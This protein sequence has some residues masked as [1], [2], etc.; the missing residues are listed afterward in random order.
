M[1]KTA[2]SDDRPH[3]ITIIDRRMRGQQPFGGRYH[4]ACLCGWMG[5]WTDHYHEAYNDHDEHLRHIATLPYVISANSYR[6]PVA[7][8]PGRVEHRVSVTA[9]PYGTDL[10]CVC[11]W[12]ML[13]SLRG[14][15]EVAGSPG[16]HALAIA[17]RHDGL[18]HSTD[19]PSRGGRS[20]RH[21]PPD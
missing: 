10:D 18:D 8:G 13:V 9:H 3:A 11:G 6:E 20:P 5:K 1:H 12:R 7:P 14:G 16:H 17:Q 21:Q 15:D 19:I 2:A 4:A